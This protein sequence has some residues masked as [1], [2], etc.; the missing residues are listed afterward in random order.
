MNACTCCSISWST[1]IHGWCLDLLPFTVAYSPSLVDLHCLLKEQPT[2]MLLS[3]K[4]PSVCSSSL[5]TYV[6][7]RLSHLNL[8]SQDYIAYWV[9]AVGEGLFPLPKRAHWKAGEKQ[10]KEFAI[11]IS[12]FLF[13]YFHFLSLLLY[14]RTLMYR[15]TLCM[16]VLFVPPPVPPRQVPLGRPW[17]SMRFL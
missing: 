17:V 10:L 3:M 5:S 8:Q 12:F 15:V 1:W 14:K 7:Q 13:F 16:Y 6:T 4:Q 9:W 2:A 11:V